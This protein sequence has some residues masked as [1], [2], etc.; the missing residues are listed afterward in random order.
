MINLAVHFQE[1]LGALPSWQKGEPTWKEMRIFGCGW[2]LNNI[3]TLRKAMEKVAKVSAGERSQRSVPRRR[4]LRSVPGR[5][6]QRSVPGRRSQ[7]SVPGSRSQ[8]SVPG[9]GR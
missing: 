3:N 9:E 7:R 2:W 6:S 5:R 4:S 8:R 1:L